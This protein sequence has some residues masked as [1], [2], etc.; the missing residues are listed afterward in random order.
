M[1]TTQVDPNEWL[2]SGGARSAKFETIGTV[3]KGV[4]VAAPELRQ[5]TDFTTGAL[6]FWDDGKPMMQLVVTV[7]TGEKDPLEDDDDGLRSF[8]IKANLQVAVKDAIR[9]AG[10]KGLEV[11]G[12]LAVKYTGDGVAKTK[13]MSPPKQFSAQYTPAVAAEDFFSDPAPAAPAAGKSA[14]DP[15]PP[16]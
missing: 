8:Y 7:D 4:I 2:M 12:K 9:K 13:G 3:V 14:A 16:F 15:E 5:Q 11:G 1:S 10:A 6:K